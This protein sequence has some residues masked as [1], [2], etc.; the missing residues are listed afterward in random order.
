VKGKRQARPARL[1]VGLLSGLASKEAVIP[2][3]REK[4]R[5][6]RAAPPREGEDGGGSRLRHVEL[7]TDLPRKTD[8]ATFFFFGILEHEF[9][10]AR[11][12][13]AAQDYQQ[14]CA[15]RWRGFTSMFG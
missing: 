15:R 6:A 2:L 3:G 7:Q 14:Y 4:V 13:E 1:D 8:A 9:R 11:L 10:R 5:Q 12:K